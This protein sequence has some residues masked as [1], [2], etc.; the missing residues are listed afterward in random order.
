MKIRGLKGLSGTNS[1]YD[2]KCWHG[3][4]LWR[5]TLLLLGGQERKD[6]SLAFP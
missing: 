1:L 2:D 6:E 4:R 5:I 3:L